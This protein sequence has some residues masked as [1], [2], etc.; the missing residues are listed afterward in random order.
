MPPRPTK[1][2]ESL[3][4]LRVLPSVVGCFTPHQEE[5]PSLHSSYELMRQTK[6]LPPTSS[7]LY[8]RS[9]QVVASPCWE[10]ALPD[11][12]SMNLSLR[13]WTSTS[14]T[15]VV[16]SPVFSHRTSAFPMWRSGRRLAT[17]VP[18]SGLSTGFISR[19]QSFLYVQARRFACHPNRSYCDSQN[20]SSSGDFY[21]RASLGLLPPRAPD[22]LTVRTG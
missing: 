7:S 21:I 20:L 13:A 17:I 22:M 3:C 9:L 1:C 12:I 16:H 8:D 14:A 19:L 18:F 6:S 2:P 15:P 5:L 11:V 10:M 4:L